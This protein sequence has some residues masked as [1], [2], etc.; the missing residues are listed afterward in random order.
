MWPYLYMS[1]FM[2]YPDKYTYIDAHLD[3]RRTS[4]V[5]ICAWDRAH[6]GGMRVRDDWNFGGGLRV[7]GQICVLEICLWMANLGIGMWI[8]G[9]W[10]RGQI[11]ILEICIWMEPFTYW[12][13]GGGLR[14]R[15]LSVGGSRVCVC[16]CA[17][18]R[19]CFWQG[20]WDVVTPRGLAETEGLVQR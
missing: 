14:V 11:C 17:R 15:G 12:D 3:W 6:Y 13:F 7:R 9:L 19:A 1:I 4:V 8:R 20:G 5:A 2:T 10:V 16:V 18:V